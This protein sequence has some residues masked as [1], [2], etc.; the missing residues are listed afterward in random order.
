[1]AR[2]ESGADG[3]AKEAA[4]AGFNRVRLCVTLVGRRLVVR[5]TM[6]SFE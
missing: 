4:T 6:D 5:K 2:S 3:V 1:M